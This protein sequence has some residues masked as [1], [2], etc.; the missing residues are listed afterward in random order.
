MNVDA[1][2][3]NWIIGGVIVI[4]LLVLA[5]WLFTKPQGLHLGSSATTTATTTGSTTTGT[6]GSTSSTTSGAGTVTTTLNGE[7]VQVDD[8]A[9]GNSVTV[10]KMNVTKSTWLAVRDATHVLGAR[11][12]EPGVTSGTIPLLRSTTKGQTYTI[13]MYVDDGDKAFDMH[14]DSLITNSGGAP[15]GDMFVAQ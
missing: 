15:V 4:I 9:A 13:V 8:Q 2:T 3:R 1:N 6:V 11:R 5:W 10:A 7:S 12:F 14:K